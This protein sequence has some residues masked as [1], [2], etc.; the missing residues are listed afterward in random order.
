[1]LAKRRDHHGFV[2]MPWQQAKQLYA[3]TTGAMQPEDYDKFMASAPKYTLE[4]LKKRVPREYHSV[5]KVFMKE[6]A[7]QLPLH[8]PEDHDI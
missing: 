7:N 3:T 1:M 2:M 6:E 4:E 5:I 8:R